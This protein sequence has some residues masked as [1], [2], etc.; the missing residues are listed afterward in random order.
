MNRR[1]FITL[2]GGAA[3][4][5]PVVALSKPAERM[6]RIGIFMSFAADDPEAQPRIA[7]FEKGMQELGWVEGHNLRTERRWVP[8]DASTLRSHAREL[9]RMA[10]ELILVKSTPA[11][12]AL[13]EQGHA[14][15]VVFVQVTDPVGQGLVASLARP[16]GNTT[17]FT[18]F[19]FSIGTKWLET[20]K[21]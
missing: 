9:L 5:W 20:L 18:T 7:A 2:M 1:R 16:G 10:P 13:Q 11:T 12:L 14:V 17:G 8:G 21:V 3:V 15:P 19:E 4:T 6:R